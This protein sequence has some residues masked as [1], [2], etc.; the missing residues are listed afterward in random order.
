[1]LGN[2]Q[3]W[4]PF[5]SRGFL[6]AAALVLSLVPLRASSQSQDVAE[7]ASKEKTRKAADEQKANH[8]YTNEDLQRSQIL[9]SDDHDRVIARKKEQPPPPASQPADAV[10]AAASHSSDSLG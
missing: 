5:S 8:V 2:W 1:M 9:T 7:A 10:D 4:R 6:F 3:V